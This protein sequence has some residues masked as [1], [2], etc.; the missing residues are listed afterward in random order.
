MIRLNVDSTFLSGHHFSVTKHRT[1]NI[2]P[3]LSAAVTGPEVLQVDIS[4]ACDQAGVVCFSSAREDTILVADAEFLG[5]HG[6]EEAR[7]FAAANWIDWRFR[8]DIVL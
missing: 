8:S 3:I 1:A 5:S 2:L 7:S 4:D 6:Y